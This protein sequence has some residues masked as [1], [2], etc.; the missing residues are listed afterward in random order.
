[1]LE[2]VAYS[3]QRGGQMNGRKTP[4]KLLHEANKAPSIRIR[5]FLNLQHFLSRVKKVPRPHVSVFNKEENVTPI[6]STA[7]VSLCV[8]PSAV[9]LPALYSFLQRQ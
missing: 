9:D 5:I 8:S 1:M 3:V 7:Y 2:E 4:D 6:K